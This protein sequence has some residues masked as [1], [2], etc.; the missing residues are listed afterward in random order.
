MLKP[1]DCH[2]GME[3]WSDGGHWRCTDIGRRTFLAIKLDQEDQRNYN[4]PPYSIAEHYFDEY[5][6]RTCYSTK[7]ERDEDYPDTYDGIDISSTVISSNGTLYRRGASNKSKWV[8][9]RTGPQG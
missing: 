3:F 2:I 8:F 4:G 5:D 9:T 6:Q 1:S 7:E